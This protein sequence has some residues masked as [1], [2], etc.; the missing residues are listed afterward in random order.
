MYNI[1]HD[2]F[3][4]LREN[5]KYYSKPD[6][7]VCMSSGYF[8]FENCSGTLAISVRFSLRDDSNRVLS[9]IE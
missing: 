1:E 7:E 5:N 4:Y 6:T 9:T 3:E 8:S 2:K